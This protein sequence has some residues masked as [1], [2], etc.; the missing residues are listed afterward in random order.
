[1]NEYN[2]DFVTSPGETI[3]EYLKEN[4]ISLNEFTNGV[5]QR[6]AGNMYIDLGDASYLLKGKLKID[7]HLA[8]AIGKFMGINP[9]FI[10]QREADYTQS[11]KNDN[12]VSFKQ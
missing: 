5:N 9:Y 7:E 8:H 10:L 12:R 6:L 1:M 11:L 2:P 4:N 3:K